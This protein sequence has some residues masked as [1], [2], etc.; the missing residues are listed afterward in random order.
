MEGLSEKW[1]FPLIVV[2]VPIYNALER[3]FGS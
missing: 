3:R 1:G 2:Y